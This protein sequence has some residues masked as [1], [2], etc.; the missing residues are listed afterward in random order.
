MSSSRLLPRSNPL[1]HRYTPFLETLPPPRRSGADPPS[2][3]TRKLK[4]S[5]QLGIL[6]L[7]VVDVFFQ[8]CEMFRSSKSESALDLACARG[9]EVLI[10]LPTSGFQS[11]LSEISG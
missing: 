4:Q 2:I 1:T 11:V 9:R 10:R 3:R 8:R 6:A 5:S 7:E